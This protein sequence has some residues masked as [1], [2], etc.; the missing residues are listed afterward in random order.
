MTKTVRLI[1]RANP[2]QDADEVMNTVNKLYE[3]TDKNIKVTIE[4]LEDGRNLAQNR[5]LF[6]WHGELGN[7]IYNSTG[8]VYNSTVIHNYVIS[9][10]EPEE[11]ATISGK[12]VVMRAE[13]KK[14]GIKKFSKLLAKYEI[15]AVEKYNCIFTQ[16]SDL[17]FDA[18]MIKQ[19]G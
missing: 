8:Q 19:E 18:L 9:E 15:W 16:P 10:L 2:R 6:K 11:V 5:L 3:S 14:M 12:A 1:K 4:I 17:Y 7:H 13:T